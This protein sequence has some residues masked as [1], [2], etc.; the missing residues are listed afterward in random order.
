MAWRFSVYFL[1]VII[2]A[3]SLTQ[4]CAPTKQHIPP[5]SPVRAKEGLQPG[6]Y[7]RV[8]HGNT[9]FGISR[10]Y[11]VSVKDIVSVNRLPEPTTIVTGQ[12]L[13]IPG[14]MIGTAKSPQNS[15]LKLG[16]GDFIWP[17][18]GEVVVAFGAMKGSVKNKGIDISATEGAEV[19]ASRTGKVVFCDDNMKGFGKT[20]IIDHGEGYSTLYGH[21]S[22]VLVSPGE[23]VRQG[24]VIARV[25]SSGRTS[26]PL[27]HFEVREGV[28]PQN[29]VY[30]LR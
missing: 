28:M 21:N 14:G 22:D 3:I 23:I 20:I 29:P 9:V 15:K 17:V 4:G 27:L 6:I 24:Q 19:V 18:N 13:Y 1:G 16:K 11:G 8:K 25:G 30:Y 12:L 7:H 10:M 26:S 2:A 5:P